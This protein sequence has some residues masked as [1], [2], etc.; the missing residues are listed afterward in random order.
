[1]RF[2]RR[3]GI[4]IEHDGC[5]PRAGRGRHKYKSHVMENSDHLAERQP[6]H[7]VFPNWIALNVNESS[8]IAAASSEPGIDYCHDTL[9]G[10][11]HETLAKNSRI[12]SSRNRGFTCFSP[13]SQLSNN[14]TILTWSDTRRPSKQPPAFRRSQSTV[15]VNKVAR[16]RLRDRD[17]QRSQEEGLGDSPRFPKSFNET[18]QSTLYS[19]HDLSRCGDVLLTDDAAPLGG[20]TTNHNA[21]PSADPAYPSEVHHMS[22]ATPD[23]LSPVAKMLQACDSMV[24]Q[25]SAQIHQ[26]QG[27]GRPRYPQERG[28]DE[29]HRRQGT[30]TFPVQ[31]HS[32]LSPVRKRYA[33]KEIKARTRNL[34]GYCYGESPQQRIGLMPD[35]RQAPST[36]AP[37]L[38]TGWWPHDSAYVGSR[39]TSRKQSTKTTAARASGD[40]SLPPAH[41]FDAHTTMEESW[42]PGSYIYAPCE[43]FREAQKPTAPSDGQVCKYHDSLPPEAAYRD[44]PLSAD[45]DRVLLEV[46]PA[47]IEGD[48]P[49]DRPYR[50]AAFPDFE[51]IDDAITP[52]DFWRPHRRC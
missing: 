20:M 44:L 50:D 37:Q 7:Q 23:D 5:R 49:A 39:S 30:A 46:P 52:I 24:T 28:I 16:D 47:E 18:A 22:H 3:C 6:L 41:G 11:G 12:V 43:G 14:E 21:S 31:M 32:R 10:S 40:R 48:W 13:I 25:D 51:P 9:N 35:V 17:I 1:M 34:E 38:E 4:P 42:C 36:V 27:L 8:H 29:R 45:D 19:A 2:L 15:S 33:R 26:I